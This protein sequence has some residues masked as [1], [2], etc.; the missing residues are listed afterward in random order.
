MSLC[1]VPYGISLEMSAEPTRSTV[2]QADNVVYFT[3]E[4][5][6][7]GL[8]FPVSSLVKGA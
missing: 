7:T 5:F 2:E 1:R 4:Q 8:R 3:W 6:A